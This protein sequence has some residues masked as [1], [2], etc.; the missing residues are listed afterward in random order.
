MKILVI[1]RKIQLLICMILDVRRGVNEI[2]A[3]FL[4]GG[5]G[6]LRGLDWYFF[7]DVARTGQ[8]I[9]PF[10]QG[11]K[12]KTLEDGTNRLSRSRNVGKKSPF[13]AV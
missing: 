10:L 12:T 8:P 4:G 11:S 9:G 6:I 3:F 13:C 2:C 5:G 1:Y 7:T